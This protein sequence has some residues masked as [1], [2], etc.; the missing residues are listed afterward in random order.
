MDETDRERDIHPPIVADSNL[1]VKSMLSDRGRKI[2]LYPNSALARK[3]EDAKR[4][5]QG[6]D[7]MC[8]STWYR[9][10]PA[11]YSCSVVEGTFVHLKIQLSLLLFPSFVVVDKTDK[12]L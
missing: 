9:T 7:P 5:K 11:S 2:F 1:A 8:A 10:F 3:K 4:R 12:H 6:K